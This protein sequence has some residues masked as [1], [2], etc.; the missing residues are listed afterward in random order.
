MKGFM[1]KTPSGFHPAPESVEDF[2]KIGMGE[3]VQVEIKKPRN[4][5]FHRK[6][7]A[8]L[9][10]SFENQDKYTNPEHFR[11]AVLLESGHYEIIQVGDKA[12]F[13]VN[14]ISFANCDEYAFS[15]IYDHALDVILEKYCMGSTKEEIDKAVLQVLDFS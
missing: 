9:K 11:K 12:V 2:E 3:I 7:F 14:S 13:D 6:F 1:V 10:V 15:K 4:I 5:K 8:L